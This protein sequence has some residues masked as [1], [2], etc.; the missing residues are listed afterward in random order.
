MFFWHKKKEYKK[1]INFIIIGN[2]TQYKLKFIIPDI[3]SV[4]QKKY[5][6]NNK[7]K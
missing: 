1:T 5:S 4:E 6:K 7:T 2:I 3:I